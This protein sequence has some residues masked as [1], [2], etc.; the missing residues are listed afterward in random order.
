MN[1]IK[2]YE[3]YI[4]DYF[5]RLY[6]KNNPKYSRGDYVLLDLDK[7]NQEW[8]IVDDN[9]NFTIPDNG[10]IVDIIIDYYEV[11]FSDSDTLQVK[12][13][14]ILRLLTKEEIQKYNLEKEANKYNL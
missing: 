13:K 5:D 12:E 9:N 6:A 3:K 11:Q 7:V 4:D 14:C 10:L 1:F 2:K 8:H